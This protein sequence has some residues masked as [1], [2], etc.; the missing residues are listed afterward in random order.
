MRTTRLVL[1]AVAAVTVLAV[2]VPAG[3]QQPITYEGSAQC[4]PAT[5]NYII[6]FT[7]Q[8]QTS[9]PANLSGGY[10][11]LDP[12]MTV[13]ASGPVT[14]V[15]NPLPASGASSAVWEVPAGTSTV[16]VSGGAAFSNFEAP[17]DQE[18]FTGTC[19]T[20]TTTAPTTTTTAP[21]PVA[22]QP[23]FTG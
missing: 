22:V 3:A 19:V 8:N 16:F 1:A 4:D 9:E 13:L 18:I 6:T 21:A 14:F 11:A 7:V 5:G 23:A 12:I 15:P 10:E 20:T 17:I 2:A